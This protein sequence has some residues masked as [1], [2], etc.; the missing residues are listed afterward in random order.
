MENRNSC[1][2]QKYL[3]NVTLVYCLL[4]NQEMMCPCTNSQVNAEGGQEGVISGLSLFFDWL[5]SYSSD[6]SVCSVLF[7]IDTA[8]LTLIDE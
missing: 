5:F 1:N 7:S 4:T 6:I 3:R 2:R 8:K